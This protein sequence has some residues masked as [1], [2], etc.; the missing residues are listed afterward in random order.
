MLELLQWRADVFRYHERRE[1]AGLSSVRPAFR[2]SER[3]FATFPVGTEH[4]LGQWIPVG[5]TDLHGFL[6]R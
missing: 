5:T 3:T 2:L 1:F 4:I 6:V